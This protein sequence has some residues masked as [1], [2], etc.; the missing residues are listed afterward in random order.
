MYLIF[1]FTRKELASTMDHYH[2]SVGVNPLQPRGDL[3]VLFSGHGQ[4]VPGHAIGPAV[5]HYYLV[6]TV[7][8]GRGLFRMDGRVYELE[9]GDTFVIFP[10]TLFSYAAD[11]DEP[12]TY[13]WVAYKGDGAADMMAALGIAITRPVLRVPSLPRALRLYRAIQR[14]FEQTP[15]ADLADLEASGLLRLLFK[16][17]G[18]A[19]R[20]RL[21]TPDQGL[22]SDI[23]RQIKRAVRWL[24]LQYAESVS[25]DDLSRTL[26]YHR[27]HFSKM[28]KQTT[29][30]SPK[31]FL[32]QVRMERAKELLDGPHE[33]QIDQ[34]AAA[35][36]YS[37]P[38]YFSKLF[39]KFAGCSPS[40]YRLSQRGGTEEDDDAAS[41]A[42]K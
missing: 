22:G 27:T 23:E 12:W 38:L 21:R 8:S 9:A 6:H 25:I 19:N 18:D 42:E 29:G 24:S 10:D 26:G 11:R 15:S 40:A 7:M 2:F 17:F 30:L 41:Q 1:T 31:Q 37:D 34:I 36:G 33:L 13:R 20:E 39:H 28:F 3:F 32:Q 5:H 16:L 14:T 4:P 35:V